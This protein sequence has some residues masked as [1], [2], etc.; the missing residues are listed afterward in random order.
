MRKV[1][2]LIERE[3]LDAFLFSSQANVFYLSGFRSTHAYAILTPGSR[4]LLTDGRYY[5]RAKEVLKDWN[6]VL[7]KGRAM[8]FLKRFLRDL[9]ARLVGYESDRVSCEMR[10]SM[11]SNRIRWKGYVNFLRD[12]RV[13]KT[14]EEIERMREGVKLSDRIYR[15]L[16]EFIKPGMTE[17][18]VRSFIVR[19]ILESGSYGESFSTIVASG[20]A[21]AIPH[22]ETSRRKIGENSPLLVDMGLVWDGY[23]TDFTRTLHIGKPPPE[24]LKIYNVVRDAHLFALEKVRVG[25]RVGDVDRAA[26]DYI[27]RKRLGKFF[28]HSTGHGIGVEIHEYPRVY[29]KGED[30]DRII[31]EGMVFTVEPGI[32]I[33]GKFGV[34]L[35]NIVATING[36]GEPLSDV[37][38]ELVVL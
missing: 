3:G 16:L 9:G 35:E 17:L 14:R 11:R 18:E 19:R 34:R 4:H 10:R 32:Y 24:F 12:I 2:E 5:E 7:I 6:V 26:R 8:R 22:W 23:C 20:E 15:E 30:A 13:L 28:V 29:F 38:L 37:D 36:R 33:P 25:N 31:E 21:T 27:K 1:Q